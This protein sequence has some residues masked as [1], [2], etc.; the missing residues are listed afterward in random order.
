LIYNVTVP[1]LTASGDGR[2]RGGCGG[3]FFC[4]HPGTAQELL[5]AVPQR[6]KPARSVPVEETEKLKRSWR[7]LFF[8]DMPGKRCSVQA[9]GMNVAGTPLHEKAGLTVSLTLWH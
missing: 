4:F 9:R 2:H 7:I 1:S 6:T 5:I 8:S 3:T